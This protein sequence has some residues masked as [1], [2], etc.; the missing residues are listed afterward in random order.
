MQ[1]LFIH[2]N[3]LKV[4]L[5]TERQF[6]N[7]FPLYA[8]HKQIRLAQKFLVY[9]KSCA[10]TNALLLLLDKASEF[11]KIVELVKY[12]CS[13][14]KEV[15]KKL[16]LDVLNRR[17]KLK[18]ILLSIFDCIE[19]SMILNCNFMDVHSKAITMHRI[20]EFTIELGNIKYF[21]NL[22]RAI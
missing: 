22:I 15:V 17:L 8:V 10:E 20:H 13:E 5:E 3:E 7:F 11:S 4:F 19:S 1:D 9:V 6:W 21:E 12:P 16:A 2:L 14:D 18:S